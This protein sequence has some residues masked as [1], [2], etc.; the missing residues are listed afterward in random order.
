MVI[1]TTMSMNDNSWVMVVRKGK[2]MEKAGFID[3]NQPF[4]VLEKVLSLRQVY[5]SLFVVEV[6]EFAL[7]FRTFIGGYGIH[8]QHDSREST[9]GFAT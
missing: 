7:S 6:I 8:A 9:V 1:D 2:D 3:R 5:F 4:L